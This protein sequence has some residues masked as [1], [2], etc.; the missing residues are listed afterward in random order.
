M[1]LVIRWLNLC[2][3]FKVPVS[4]EPLNLLPVLCSTS[5]VIL[6]EKEVSWPSPFVLLGWKMEIYKVNY[7]LI[8]KIIFL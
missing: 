8:Y 6:F 1:K 2:P 4:D 5:T 3:L 7:F